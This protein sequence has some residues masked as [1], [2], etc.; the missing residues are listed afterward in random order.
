[1][2]RG[3]LNLGEEARGGAAV[4]R[5]WS[6]WTT[7]SNTRSSYVSTTSN[8]TALSMSCHRSG[9]SFTFTLRFSIP[10]SPLLVYS[11]SSCAAPPVS[12]RAWA[13][14]LALVAA[15]DTRCAGFGGLDG[16]GGA[17]S[18]RSL[19]MSA[20]GV[21][22]SYTF[23][24]SC[25][26]PGKRTLVPV[27]NDRT[28]YPRFCSWKCDS[29]DLVG[30]AGKNQRQLGGVDF[31]G[32]LRL[33]RV[34][35]SR[36]TRS[37]P[38][39]VRGADR[40]IPPPH[41]VLTPSPR[42]PRALCWPFLNAWPHHVKSPPTALTVGALQAYNPARVALLLFCAQQGHTTL[43]RTAEFGLCRAAL[44]RPASPKPARRIRAPL[45]GPER[46]PEQVLFFRLCGSRHPAWRGGCLIAARL[47]L[48]H[49]NG[50]Q[51]VLTHA[52]FRCCICGPGAAVRGS[53]CFFRV[54]RPVLCGAGG[55][56]GAPRYGAVDHQQVLPACPRGT[57]L[58]CRLVTARAPRI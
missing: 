8:G 31:G 24:R 11:F 44:L 2:M 32:V 20:Y 58:S 49:S 13:G 12:A 15:G 41:R 18:V 19:R 22:N 50:H 35:G 10:S 1:M 33:A 38:V 25:D 28:E 53:L 51:N 42:N 39:H 14:P 3:A 7:A 17:F 36:G 46:G 40:R 6:S 26:G 56:A 54:E 9:A 27:P 37:R 45:L 55:G 48:Q 34:G 5:P 30:A 52:A 29:I 23:G 21:P 47:P 43:R 16:Q 4:P 57:R